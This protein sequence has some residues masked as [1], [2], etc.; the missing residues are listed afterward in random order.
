MRMDL[1]IKQLYAKQSGYSMK[2]INVIN[3]RLTI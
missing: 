1:K 2:F 3:R